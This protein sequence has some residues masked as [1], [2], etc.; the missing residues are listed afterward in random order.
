V[1]VGALHQVPVGII[2][3]PNS[4]KEV[5][6]VRKVTKGF[7]RE[8]AKHHESQQKSEDYGRTQADISSTNISR[9]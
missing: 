8:G 6:K 7:I 9:E 2:K 4:K 3:S 1:I 5:G